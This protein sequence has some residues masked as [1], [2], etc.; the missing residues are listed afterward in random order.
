MRT[1]A[2]TTRL[3]GVVLRYR[4][5]SVFIGLALLDTG[6]M[7]AFWRLE[8]NPLLVAAGPF[9]ATIFKILPVAGLVIIWETFDV[10]QSTIGRRLLHGLTAVYGLVAI[11]NVGVILA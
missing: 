7:L 9:W 6:L 3:R 1:A 11:T 8:G 5:V 2:A 4:V 10:H